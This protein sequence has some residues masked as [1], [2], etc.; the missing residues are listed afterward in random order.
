METGCKRADVVTLEVWSSSVLFVV[1]GISSFRSSRPLGQN[2]LRLPFASPAKTR[3]LRHRTRPARVWRG[4]PVLSVKG[5]ISWR[6][7]LVSGRP[8][9]AALTLLCPIP[10][11][12]YHLPCCDIIFLRTYPAVPFIFYALLLCPSFS[13]HLPC[14]DII[15]L[16]TSL[17]CPSFST[18]LPCCA[19]FPLFELPLLL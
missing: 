8:P 14:C 4:G 2:A 16:R 13:T 12:A 18:H 19:L 7:T 9:P 15:F 6:T 1:A 5:P 10:L 3:F 17:P 11:C